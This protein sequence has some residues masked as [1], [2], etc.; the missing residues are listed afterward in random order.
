M[1][2]I[3]VLHVMVEAGDTLSHIAAVVYGDDRR[4]PEIFAANRH[5]IEDPNLIYPGQVLIIPNK[6]SLNE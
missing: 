3:P 6:R 1:K 4:W 5:V 2:T